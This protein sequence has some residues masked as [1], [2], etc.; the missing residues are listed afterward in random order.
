VKCSEVILPWLDTNQTPEKEE[1][2]HKLKEVDRACQDIKN[3]Y[4]GNT[5]FGGRMTE[6]GSNM[7]EAD[8]K[9]RSLKLR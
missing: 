7:E 1:F 5:D 8:E 2:G 9:I 6:Q 4:Q 3:F